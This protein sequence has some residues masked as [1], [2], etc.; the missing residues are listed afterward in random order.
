MSLS[1]R[2]ALA[3]LDQPLLPQSAG[4]NWRER[5]HVALNEHAQLTPEVMLDALIAKL[6]EDPLGVFKA[7]VS[8]LPKEL[9][10]ASQPQQHHLFLLRIVNQAHAQGV[11]LS[12]LLTDSLTTEPPTWLS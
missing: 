11:D 4:R 7:I 6:P 2:D 8:T 12:A 1:N 10:I 9:D 3:S 5:F